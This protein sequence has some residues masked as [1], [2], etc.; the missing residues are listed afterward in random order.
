MPLLVKARSF[1]RNILLARR[2]ESELD[3]EVGVHL[4]MLTD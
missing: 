3:E 4:E 2:V 1:V